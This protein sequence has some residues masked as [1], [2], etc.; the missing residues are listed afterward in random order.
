MSFSEEAFADLYDRFDGVTWYVQSVLN[1]VWQRGDGFNSVKDT[2]LAVKSL[3]E[4]RNL[5]FLDLLN[6]QSEASKAVLRAVAEE[7]VVAQPTGKAFLSGHS[8]GAAS[9]ISSVVANLVDHELLYKTEK[10][11][12]V[13]DRLFALWMKRR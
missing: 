2:E 11:Y 5:V 3:V 13:Y 9:T 8:L 4:N 12:V 1:R 6:S 7:D 10:G